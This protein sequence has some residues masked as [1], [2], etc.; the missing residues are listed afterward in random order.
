MPPP[1]VTPLILQGTFTHPRDR[2]R[3][4][5]LPLGPPAILASPAARG[6]G[7]ERLTW[8][9]AELVRDPGGGRLLDGQTRHEMERLYG[10]SF[11]GVTVHHSPQLRALGARAVTVGERIHFAVGEYEPASDTGATLLCREL[12]HVVQQRQLIGPRRLAG[13]PIV[14]HPWLEAEATRRGLDLLEQRRS[15]RRAGP[16]TIQR[17]DPL[18]IGLI[19]VGVTLGVVA[20][21]AIGW[22]LYRAW[23][24]GGEEATPLLREVRVDPAEAFTLAWDVTQKEQIGKQPLLGDVLII[25]EAS[26]PTERTGN[27]LTGAGTITRSYWPGEHWFKNNAAKLDHTW[28]GWDWVNDDF[29]NDQQF[30][31]IIARSMVCSCLDDHFVGDLGPEG[32]DAKMT[33]GGIGPDVRATVMVRVLALLRAGGQAIFTVSRQGAMGPRARSIARTKTRAYWQPVFEELRTHC[34]VIELYVPDRGVEDEPGG[35]FFGFI[36]RRPG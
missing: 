30:D 11:A 16:A 14:R 24:R 21:G 25:S 35:D 8:A 23:R 19:V 20:L 13:V 34:T 3:A 36:I 9:P 5:A 1:H 22:C 10:E 27:L 29:P 12:G 2:A 33:C 7:A 32:G 31:T 18:T 4:P 26:K 28:V 15:A 6:L 17:M